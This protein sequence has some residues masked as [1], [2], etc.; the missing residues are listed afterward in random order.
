MTSSYTYGSREESRGDEGKFW[1]CFSGFDAAAT[2]IAQVGKVGG[3][4]I[5]LDQKMTCGHSSRAKDFF[6]QVNI[7]GASLLARVTTGPHVA[8]FHEFYI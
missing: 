7:A 1:G 5:K 6:A 2:V 4:L 3:T 8:S